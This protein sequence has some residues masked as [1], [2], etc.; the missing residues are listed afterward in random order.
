MAYIYIYT[1]TDLI[2]LHTFVIII[3]SP[4]YL[5]LSYSFGKHITAE[6]HI[7][8]DSVIPKII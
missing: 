8:I 2:K 7:V 6:I 5:A 3:F 1:V 4:K